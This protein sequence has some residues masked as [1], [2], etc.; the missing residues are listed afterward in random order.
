MDRQVS[1]RTLTLAA[2]AAVLLV[3][4][5]AVVGYCAR[6]A[7]SPEPPGAAPAGAG[8]TPVSGLGTVPL[9]ELPKEAA[10]T[11]ALIDKG[12]PYPYRK[13]GT[14]FAN[15]EGLLPA[16]PNGYYREFTVPTPGSPDR[17]ARRVI[18]GRDGD[19]YYTSDHYE[20]FRQ[21]LR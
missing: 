13:D 2:V 21:I 12:G 1:R 11:V 5:M 18:A 20:S 17:G 10:A 6:T 7:L 14:V 8:A 16:R 19:L 15:Q 3:A 4:L 9:A